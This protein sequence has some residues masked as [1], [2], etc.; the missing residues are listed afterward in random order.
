MGSNARVLYF[1][2]ETLPNTG[3][4]FELGK[5]N[6]SYQQI[7]KE[8]KIFCICWKWGHERRI[9]SLVMNLKLHDRLAYDDDADK[10]M[11]IKFVKVYNSAD[12]AVGHN[13]FK[14]DKG[15]IRG[16]LFKHGLTDLE[17]ILIDDT[18][19]A[20]KNLR[21]NCHKLDYLSRYLGMS[22]KVKTDFQL[23]VD[24]YHG[25]IKAYHTMVKY[26]KN[27]VFPLLEEMHTRLIPFGDFKFNHAAF[28]GDR[29]M[30]PRCGGHLVKHDKR[31]SIG[32]Q[33]RQQYKCTECGK[34]VT[35]G[36]NLLKTPGKYPR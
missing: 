34:Y 14:F 16:R 11:L 27:D 18:Y 21:L 10:E 32:L 29:M 19:L 24:A 31:L 22:R 4:F 25:D 1:D 33:I 23:W 8:G 12:Y 30:C 26:C 15:W 5:T 2:I 17:P 20:S 28:N 9:H 3:L 35:T 7:I 36:E 6:I 13:A